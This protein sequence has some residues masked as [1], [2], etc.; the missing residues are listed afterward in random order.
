MSKTLKLAFVASLVL[1]LLLIGVLVGQV[2]R[3]SS[4]PPGRQQRM[5]QALQQLPE[6]AQSRLRANFAAIRAAGEPFRAK[7][8]QAR[9]DALR[10]LSTEPFDEAAYSARLREMEELRIE[11]I[12]SMGQRIRQQANELSP[13]ER[14]M[15]ADLFGRPPRSPEQ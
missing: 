5:E 13:E 3:A 6:P 7:I 12:K 9:A 1:N 15:V 11:S 8:E 4:P 10:L 2:P 14:R